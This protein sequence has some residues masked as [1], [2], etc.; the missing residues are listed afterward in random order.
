MHH[1]PLWVGYVLCNIFQTCWLQNPFFPLRMLWDHCSKE[2]TLGIHGSHDIW[3]YSTGWNFL[4]KF[5]VC[6]LW[7]TN[8]QSVVF[9]R[10][11]GGEKGGG[12]GGFVARYLQATQWFCEMGGIWV[13][14]CRRRNWS[15]ERLKDRSSPSWNEDALLVMRLLCTSLVCWGESREGFSHIMGS[16]WKLQVLHATKH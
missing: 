4:F 10:L 14:F 8:G 7:V 12:G 15:L 9:W 2:H 3:A 6:L 16:C 5:G 11:E 13:K 1:K